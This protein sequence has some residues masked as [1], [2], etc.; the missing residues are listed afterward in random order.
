MEP[1]QPNQR[2]E[3]SMTTTTAEVTKT[4]PF[5]CARCSTRWG[6]YN[7]AHC[8]GCHRTFTS[9]RSFDM[10]RRGGRCND[11]AAFGLVVNSRGYWAQAGTKP[12]STDELELTR[13]VSG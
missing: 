7:T 3:S 6:G 2:K 8:G 10:H 4:P 5:G 13:P 1:G 9:V 12:R 11:P